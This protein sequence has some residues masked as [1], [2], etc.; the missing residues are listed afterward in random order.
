MNK[1]FY[2]S[3]SPDMIVVSPDGR[4]SPL[5]VG[6][7]VFPF[8]NHSKRTTILAVR[9]DRGEGCFMVSDQRNDWDFVWTRSGNMEKVAEYYRNQHSGYD[10]PKS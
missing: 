7:E 10:W 9:W 4:V 1:R 5:Q 2:S 6:D 3:T 8:H